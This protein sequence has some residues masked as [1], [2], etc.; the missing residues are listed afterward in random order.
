MIAKDIFS[1]DVFFDSFFDFRLKIT[2]KK[3]RRVL[4]EPDFKRVLAFR[5]GDVLVKCK[6]WMEIKRTCMLLES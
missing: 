2:I 6:W 5:R 1:S 4:T 3:R